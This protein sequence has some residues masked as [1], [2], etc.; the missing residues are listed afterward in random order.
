MEAKKTARAPNLAWGE[1]DQDD[2]EV[3]ARVAKEQPEW[4][5]IFLY[6]ETRMGSEEEAKALLHYNDGLF[7]ALFVQ[8]WENTIRMKAYNNAVVRLLVPEHPYMM[9]WRAEERRLGLSGLD[10]RS[11]F[12]QAVF[13]S[14][15]ARMEG[16]LA[17]PYQ[18]FGHILP[19]WP[20][21]D[22]VNRM[23]LGSWTVFHKS[24]FL[25]LSLARFFALLPD[26]WFGDLGLRELD[27][28]ETA[29]ALSVGNKRK[30]HL[31][32]GE[33]DALR[34]FEQNTRECLEKE[35]G[36]REFNPSPRRRVF[37]G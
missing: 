31:T 10:T 14:L 22:S 15:G 37:R 13:E 33:L 11:D 19:S 29:L 1:L 2:K 16:R 36:I 4:A 24:H 9:A 32:N 30:L 25:D 5:R 21:G 6:G 35:G 20:K 17:Y 27:A 28:E 8:T 12:I 34:R 23:Y 26:N 3:V 18:R 7:D